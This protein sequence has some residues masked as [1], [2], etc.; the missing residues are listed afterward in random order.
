AAAEAHQAISAAQASAAAV[1][2]PAQNALP[3]VE[4]PKLA[5]ELPAAAETHA[6]PAADEPNASESDRDAA[7]RDFSSLLGEKLVEGRGDVDAPAVPASGGGSSARLA[8]PSRVRSLSAAPA[9]L[10]AALPR[11][12]LNGATWHVLSRGGYIVGNVGAAIFPL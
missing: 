6:A 8:A 1:A 5:A 4:S 12:H 2:A 9:V 3:K 7:A 11:F 10:A